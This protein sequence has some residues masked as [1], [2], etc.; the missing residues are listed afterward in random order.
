MDNQ[1][2]SDLWTTV[3]AAAEQARRRLQRRSTGWWRDE[4]APGVTRADRVHALVVCIAA[5]DPTGRGAPPRPPHDAT[6][7][8][9]LA[10]VAYDV[11]LAAEDGHEVDAETVLE[12]L[13][14]GLRDVDPR[15]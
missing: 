15:S 1:P 10:V 2:T 14:R 13:A 6:L 4:V 5:L 11:R 7:A 12:E 9:H 8:D 3:T